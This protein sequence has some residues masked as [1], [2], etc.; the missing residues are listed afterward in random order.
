M[1][2]FRLDLLYIKV[3]GCIEVIMIKEDMLLQ[4]FE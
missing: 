1:P 3:A 2:Y 4:M